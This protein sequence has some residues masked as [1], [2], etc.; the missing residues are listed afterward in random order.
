M[1][2]VRGNGEITEVKQLK[3]KYNSKMDDHLGSIDFV[4]FQFYDLPNITAQLEFKK[5]TQ[6]VSMVSVTVHNSCLSTKGRCIWLIP[7]TSSYPRA[8]TVC[9]H[10]FQA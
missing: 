3:T 4:F 2:A 10:I 5:K 9:R 1:E 8:T 7:Q 6:M